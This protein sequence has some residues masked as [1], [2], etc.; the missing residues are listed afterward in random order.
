MV[1]LFFHTNYLVVIREFVKI[2]WLTAGETRVRLQECRLS[3]ALYVALSIL[4]FF[5]EHW[6]EESHCM[7]V[8]KM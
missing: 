1:F 3:R 5:V 6:R 2:D 8:R 7:R 4:M